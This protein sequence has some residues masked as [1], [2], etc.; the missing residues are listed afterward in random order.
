[1]IREGLDRLVRAGLVFQRGK[2]PAAEYQFKHALVQDT[3]YG[4][5]LRGARQ[6]LHQRIATALRD[7]SPETV[8]RAPE[9]LAHHLAAAG[10]LNSAAAHW[11]E[12]GRR[13]AARSA[14]VEAV[15]HLTRG[16]EVLAGVADTSER[17]LQELALQ[18]ALGPALMST[19]GF[20]A[21]EAET[22]YQNARWLAEQLGD[23][24]AR[25]ASV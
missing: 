18:L 19:R 21:P 3:A 12:A 14:N 4:T 9:V 20:D 23:D 25:F 8:E 24:N 11:L 7:Q 5:L 1:V 6:R 15:R 2:P 22:A 10:Q 16:I 17:T 13:A